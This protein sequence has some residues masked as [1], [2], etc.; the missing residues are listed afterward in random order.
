M[1]ADAETL[2]LIVAALV[3]SAV[4]VWAGLFACL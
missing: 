4:T 2:F 3:V 1:T